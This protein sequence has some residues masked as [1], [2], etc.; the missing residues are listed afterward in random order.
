MFSSS[1]YL[2][3]G[4]TINLFLYQTLVMFFSGL[5]FFF[6]LPIIFV[7]NFSNQEPKPI[8]QHYKRS[9]NGFV[10]TLTKE[11]ASKMAGV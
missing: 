2:T 4:L 1:V 3:I 5:F 9:F 8:L 7:H 6:I 11:E 10:V